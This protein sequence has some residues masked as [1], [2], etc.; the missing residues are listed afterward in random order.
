MLLFSCRRQQLFIE[1]SAS[2]E[3]MP[4]LTEIIEKNPLP[5]SFTVHRTDKSVRIGTLSLENGFPNIKKPKITTTDKEAVKSTSPEDVLTADIKRSYYTFTTRIWDQAFDVKTEDPD[6]N[7][8]V[9]IEK[10]V[11]P[12]RAVSI[13]GMYPDNPEYP[14]VK[15]T[16]LKLIISDSLENKEVLTNWFNDLHKKYDK[17]LENPP[18]ITW[19]GAVGDIMVQRGV[20]EILTGSENGI[21]K[22]FG[23]TAGIIRKQ[24]LFLGNLEGTVTER[25][26]K[27]PKSYNFKFHASVLPILSRAGFDYL[28]LTNNH[29]YDYGKAGFTDTLNNVKSS[30]IATSGSGINRSE[31]ERYWQTSAADGT[32]IRVL[33]LG[34]YPRENNGFDGKKQASASDERPGI[35]FEG[36]DADRAV[37]NMVSPDT[38]DIL[39]IHGGVEWTYKPTKEQKDLYR[40]YIDMGADL[41]LGSH[42]HVLQ[43]IEAYK[44]KLIAY[45]LGNFIFPGM[46]GMPHAEESVILTLGIVNN[47]IVYV[48]P[49]P[50]KINDKYISLDHGTSGYKRFLEL[51]KDVNL[52]QG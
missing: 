31:A 40:R 51:V 42:P 37:K 22:I 5:E 32:K 13:N 14:G 1:L 48:V 4:E 46:G 36:P 11:L 28:S 33:S 23:D 41:V 49:Y 24:D 21:G 50:V 45:S 25:T 10:V 44:N 12:Y 35:L 39:F 34:A 3:L 52:N 9:P 30:P 15:V 38:F 27:T 17:T 8:L 2:S 26:S 29:V 6:I 18:H 7:N 16:S 19:I 47:R 20:Q 43:G